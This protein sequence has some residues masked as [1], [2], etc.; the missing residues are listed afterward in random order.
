MISGKREVEI[1]E[2]EKSKKKT[3]EEEKR[4]IACEKEKEIGEHVKKEKRFKKTFEK[5]E[6]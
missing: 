5:G 6:K 1:Y 3:C 2:I 4:K